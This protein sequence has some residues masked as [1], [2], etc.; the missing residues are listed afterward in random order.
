MRDEINSSFKDAMKS[1]DQLRLSTLRLMKA[2]I[3]ERDIDARGGEEGGTCG[4]TDIME[5]LAKMIKQ[6]EE[7]ARQYETG[8]RVE[9]CERERAEIEIIREFLPAPLSED[10]VNAA[11]TEAI[12]STGASSLKDMG[13]VMGVLR[14]QYLGRM[15]FGAVGK[16]VK[17]SLAGS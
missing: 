4:E 17:A 14:E 1:R 16:Q 3:A 11:V 12:E 10:E 15:D 8:G 6:R 13:A 5:L 7:S 9:L 2:A